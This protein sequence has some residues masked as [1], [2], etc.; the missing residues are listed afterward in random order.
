[1]RKA[2]KPVE[3]WGLKIAYKN[4]D[5]RYQAMIGDWFDE[6]ICKAIARDKELDDT[7][8]WARSVR[9]RIEEID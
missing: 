7:V 5:I 9:L 2:K 8:K 1:M 4:G 3:V 6:G